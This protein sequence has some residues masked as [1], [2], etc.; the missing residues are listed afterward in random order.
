MGG[1]G[2]SSE[3]SKIKNF[4]NMK[5]IFGKQN[6]DNFIK[7]LKSIEDSPMKSLIEKLGN[8]LQFEKGEGNFVKG[9]IIQ[10]TDSSFKEAKD[11][12]AMQTVFHEIGHGIDNL[13]VRS[14]GIDLKSVSSDPYY[15]LKKAINKDLL[16]KFNDDLKSIN[17]KDYQKLKSLKKM[18][19]FDQGAI[20]RKYKK[21]SESNPKAYSSLSDM[22]ESTGAFIHHPLGS[23]HGLKYWKNSGKQETEFVAHMS[24][25]MVNKDARK[26]MNEIFPNA[27]KAYERMLNDILKSLKK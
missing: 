25:S 8:Q 22:M 2:A 18:S 17:G 1:R 6:H 19:I 5:D 16:S 23:G 11:R 7:K 15:G 24:E 12:N 13:G 4:S 9:K 10:L 21:L 27:S 14:L 3:T 26:M 20:V